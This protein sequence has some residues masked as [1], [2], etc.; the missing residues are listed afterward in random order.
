MPTDVEVYRILRNM[1]ERGLLQRFA[2]GVRAAHKTG[3]NSDM[4]TEC[5]LFYLP[6]LRA[7]R[8]RSRAQ[9]TEAAPEPA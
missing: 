9:V 5:S 7:E 1:G 3:A 6:A 4:R 8:L 2:G